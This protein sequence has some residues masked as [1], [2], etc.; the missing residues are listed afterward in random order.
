MT[1][2][3]A[4]TEGKEPA[5]LARAH[6]WKRL[7]EEGRYRLVAELAVTER[8]NKGYVSRILNL[9]LLAPDLTDRFSTGVNQS[10]FS[11]KRSRGE[12][13]LTG[14]YNVR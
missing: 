3:Q 8:I 11:W 2:P 9:T 14:A 12:Y 6:R 5:A 13:L 7:L 1:S 10:A 4:G